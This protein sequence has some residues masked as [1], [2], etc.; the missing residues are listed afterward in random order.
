MHASICI[1]KRPLFPLNGIAVLSLSLGLS[2]F[3]SA[4]QRQTD[5]SSYWMHIVSRE[6][7]SQLEWI[8][9]HS[10]ICNVHG[11]T[12][13]IGPAK[14]FSHPYL[15][16]R[17]IPKCDVCYR[18]KILEKNLQKNP[19]RKKHSFSSVS[20]TLLPYVYSTVTRQHLGSQNYKS[21]KELG[22]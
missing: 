7:C 17:P 4:L 8:L 5:Q 2:N 15:P 12:R 19:V 1:T 16:C 20:P 18:V 14:W 21:L 10:R 9:N 3:Q 6:I 13:V 11:D 22:K